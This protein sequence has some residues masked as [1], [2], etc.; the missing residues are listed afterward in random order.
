MRK[1]EQ[2]EAA[3]HWL[4]DQRERRGM[5][6]RAFA[7]KLDVATQMVYDWQ[8]G[9]VGV[10]DERAS[11]VADVL[12]LPELEVRRGLGLWVPDEENA[13]ESETEDEDVEQ[14]M[15]RVRQMPR[16]DRRALL[17]LLRASDQMPPPERTTEEPP[18][19]RRH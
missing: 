5:S 6:V 2:L 1:R 12:D 19:E 13:R 17:R 10:S 16:E 3:G 15:R 7:A 8:N 9:K 18:E 4:R 11:Q 14:L